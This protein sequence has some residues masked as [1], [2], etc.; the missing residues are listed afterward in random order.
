MGH[1]GEQADAFDGVDDVASPQPTEPELLELTD[2][3]AP[4]TEPPELAGHGAPSEK[5]DISARHHLILQK[6]N[7]KRLNVA[8]AEAPSAM[9]IAGL[10]SFIHEKLAISHHQ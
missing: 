8:F 6:M 1:R 2:H 4:S 10:K 9:S 3:V 7:G 5:T